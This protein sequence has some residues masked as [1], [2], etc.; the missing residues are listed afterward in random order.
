[1]SINEKIVQV[2]ASFIGETEIS[3]NMGFKDKDFEKRM[4]GLS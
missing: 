4:M 1:M 3:G 2:A